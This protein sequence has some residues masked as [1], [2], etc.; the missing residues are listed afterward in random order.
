MED[1]YSKTNIWRFEEKYWLADH[2]L[3]IEESPVR[4]V[5]DGGP[6][7]VLMATPGQEREL[8][9][10]FALTMGWARPGDPAPAAAWHPQVQEVRL[11]G[12]KTPPPEPAIVKSVGGGPLGPTDVPQ[13]EA[14]FYLEQE[15][16]LGL[17]RT[18]TQD[19]RLYRKTGASHA[20][21]I[22]DGT[23]APLVLAEDAG[24]HN[25]LDKAV[26]ALWLQ[27]RLSQARAVSFSG[28]LSL[29][30]VLKAARAGMGVLVGVSAPTAPA[31]RAAHEARVTVGGFSRGERLNLYTHPWRVIHKGKPLSW[32]HEGEN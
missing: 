14:E 25:A 21:A 2:D 10:G 17:T 22:F 31:V 6:K 28:R 30:M 29:E 24:R 8:A 13:V 27:G 7:T 11:N 16:V 32:E 12:L 18:M 26:G 19:Q 5:V 20:A 15:V 9:A 1:A 23:G 4:L 3:L